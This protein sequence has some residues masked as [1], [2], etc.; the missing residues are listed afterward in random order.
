MRYSTLD[1]WSL[2][3]PLYWRSTRFQRRDL[4]LSASDEASLI[5]SS[6]LS[7]SS[8]S[9]RLE[10]WSTDELRNPP[11]KG[12]LL[13]L[14]HRPTTSRSYG[15]II[16]NFALF[17]FLVFGVPCARLGCQSNRQ[18]DGWKHYYRYVWYGRVRKYTCIL[19]TNNKYN[20]LSSIPKNPKSP[21][22]G[23]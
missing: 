12:A 22:P 14:S 13:Y 11:R 15:R 8:A 6:I 9:V 17:A 18:S 1:T 10:N 3:S 16:S 2:S 7:S 20:L 23:M 4:A 5:H 21:K 19:D